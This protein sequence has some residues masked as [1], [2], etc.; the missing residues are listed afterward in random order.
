MSLFSHRIVVLVGLGLLA[1]GCAAESSDAPSPDSPDSPEAPA[2][3]PLDG[4]SGTRTPNGLMPL[5]YQWR[6]SQL[7]ALLQMPLTVGGQMN[8]DQAFTAFLDNEAGAEVFEY[9]IQCALPAGMIYGKFVGAGLMATTDSWVKFPLDPQQRRDVHTC[10][11]TRLNPLVEHVN[12]WIGGPDTTKDTGSDDFIY[13]EALWSVEIDDRSGAFHFSVWP[14]ET[15]T[16]L[17]VCGN[18]VSGQLADVSSRLCDDNAALCDIDLRYDKATVCKGTPGMGDWVCNGMPAI[19]T[20]LGFGDW[21]RLHPGC[22]LG[23]PPQ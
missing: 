3:R 13:S 17:T 15:F 18:S 20:R 5:E 12:I 23:A 14:L 11:S 2:L 22:Q 9:A 19:E 10:I 6:R 16:N 21:N 8:P 7:D 1:A 4:P